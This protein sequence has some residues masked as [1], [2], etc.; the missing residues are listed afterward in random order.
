MTG[1]ELTVFNSESILTGFEY[2][3]SSTKAFH[4]NF[5][6][7]ESQLVLLAGTCGEAIMSSSKS[8]YLDATHS[9]V[10]NF[11]LEFWFSAL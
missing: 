3:I 4:P 5:G 2:I 10:S 6:F 11:C 7:S 8:D 9:P 1:K